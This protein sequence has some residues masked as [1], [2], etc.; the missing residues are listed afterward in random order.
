M[1]SKYRPHMVIL[2]EDDANRQI[3]NGFLKNPAIDRNCIQIERPAGGWLKTLESFKNNQVAGL[4]RWP[5]RIVVLLIDFDRDIGRLD[6]FRKQ[7]D[8]SA[9]L[10][11]RVFILGARN[12]PE[13][14]KRAVGSGSLETIGIALADD[15]RS[16][17][18]TLWNHVEL[19]HNSN[20]LDR[21]NA[22]VKPWLFCQST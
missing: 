12:E 8:I 13:D 15:C 19:A 14:I 22:A 4:R 7:I 18:R 9:D 20:E 11:N 17:T 5:L 2:P 16:N 21:L 10:M 3:V 1:T 6:Y